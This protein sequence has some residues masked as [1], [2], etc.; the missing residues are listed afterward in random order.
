M[1]EAFQLAKQLTTRPSD[2]YGIDDELTAWSFDR[3]VQT[4]GSSL[5]SRLHEVAEKAKTRAAVKRKTEQELNKWLS[6]ADT[7]VAA[8]RF[9]DPMGMRI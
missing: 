6:S 9:R 2:M 5:E 3:A 8:G 4:F 1:W 7:K